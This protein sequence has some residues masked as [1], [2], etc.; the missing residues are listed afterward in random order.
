MIFSGFAFLVR[1]LPCFLLIYF[2]TPARFR[3]GILFL[4]S[5]VF[6]A[7]GEPAG[8]LLL[9]GELLVNHALYTLGRHL[10]RRWPG[11]LAALLDIAVLA[12]FKYLPFYGNSLFTLLGMDPDAVRIA[13]PAGISFFTFRMISFLSDEHPTKQKKR[14]VNFPEYA[15]YVAFFPHMISGPVTKYSEMEGGLLK[16]AFSK[17]KAEEGVKLLVIG[18][19]YKLLLGD[20]LGTVWNSVQ[21]AGT[22][23]LGAGVAWLGA[24]AYTLQIYFDF[25]G[26]S[27][28]AIG[29]GKILGFH[30]PENFKEPYSATSFSD[31]WRRWHITLGRWFREYVYIPLGGSRRGAFRT[32]LNLLIVWALTGI[33]H[34]ATLNFL[35]WG[36]V[37]FLLLTLERFVYGKLLKKV[38]LLGHFYVLLLLPVTWVIFALSDLPTLQGYLLAMIGMAPGEILTGNAV[39]LRMLHTYCPILTAG[40]VFATPL[41]R[42]LWEKW[43][44][45]FLMSLVLFALLLLCCREM[46][47]GSSNPFLYFRF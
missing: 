23:G 40:L 10:G 24:I 28:M 20:P 12:G 33:W 45:K 13:M 22:A 42:K 14:R 47:I 16:N 44:K 7:I 15:A 5:L 37:F 30:L 31:F 21:T 41:P 36:G 17:E 3:S 19:S 2:L 1:F 11:V 8:I 6:Y 43:G 4:G 25:F 46:T 35:L 32:I 18:L 27:L 38:P 29:L 34:G 9:L 39:L 26:Y